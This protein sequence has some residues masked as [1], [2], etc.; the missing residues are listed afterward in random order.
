M[1]IFAFSAVQF[2]QRCSSWQRAVRLACKP[3]EEQCLVS[4]EYAE[5]IIA[6][7]EKSGPWYILTSGFAMPHAR[8]EQG[9]LSQETH[10]SLLRIRDNVL[11]EGH[12]AVGLLIVLAAGSGS[13]HLAK[14]QQLTQWLDEEN[15]LE[16]LLATD[17]E[18]ALLHAIH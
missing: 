10:L 3:L 13:D 16:E 4:Q 8:P 14:I 1:P 7:T 17:N 15:R 11:F 9:V 5:A 18:T 12:D 6:E 2:V